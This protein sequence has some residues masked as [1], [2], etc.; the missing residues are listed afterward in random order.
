MKIKKIGGF[1]VHSFI[2]SGWIGL[3]CLALAA[4]LLGKKRN[5]CVQLVESTFY[6]YKGGFTPREA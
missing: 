6:N 1:I 4:K 3:S 2:A 5:V